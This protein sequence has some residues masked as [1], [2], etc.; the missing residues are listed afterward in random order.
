VPVPV[1][2]VTGKIDLFHSPDFVLP[3][4]SGDVP[5]LLTVHDLSFVHF[6]DTFTPALINYLN[7]VV[8]RSVDRATHILADSQ[9]TKEDLV[10]IWNVPQNKITVLYSG[11]SGKFRPVTEK[12][13][14]RLVREKYGLGDDPY[15]L[16][17]GTVQPRKNF[18]MLFRAFE[19][20][21]KEF[22]HNLFIA[23]GKGWLY[24]KVLVDIER[25]GL[26]DRVR[27]IGFVDDADLPALYSG[28]T[29]FLFPSI[30][31]GFGLPLLEA[32]ACGVPVITSDA[33]SLP[34]V[35]GEAAIQLSPEQPERWT[36]AIME[37][38]NDP[39]RRAALVAAGFI[40]ARTFTWTK[41]SR[42]LASIYDQLLQS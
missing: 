35:S 16:S 25:R 6:P 18:Q 3:A 34:E 20:V 42:Q 7:G 41:A 32:M 39:G 13:Q 40:Q 21:A 38:L 5:S 4:I 11:V 10:N 31:E 29:L 22:E 36:S 1:Q 19:P 17:V 12:E 9:A 15:F 14:L 23:G 37:L 8:P 27:F 33:S 2:L 28:A 24:E 30:Y 26:T